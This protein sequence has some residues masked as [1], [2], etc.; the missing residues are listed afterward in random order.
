METRQPETARKAER[1]WPARRVGAVA[2]WLALLGFLLPA[3]LALA[4]AAQGASSVP[5]LPAPAEAASPGGAAA[6]ALPVLFLVS[7]LAEGAALVLGLLSRRGSLL[8]A[9]AAGSALLALIA[10]AVAVVALGLPAP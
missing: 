1:V 4:L 9:I 3:A 6:S 8:G 10:L 2:L 5:L 7:L